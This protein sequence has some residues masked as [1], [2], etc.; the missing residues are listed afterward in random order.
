MTIT[1]IVVS[2]SLL[3]R[4]LVVLGVLSAGT[5]EVFTT[6]SYHY[7]KVAENIATIGSFTREDAAPYLWEPYRLPLLP[8][9]MAL[10]I[11][12]TDDVWPVIFL[13]PVLAAIATYSVIKLGDIIHPGTGIVS[14]VLLA[15]YPVALYWDR[16][17]LTDSIGAYG[18]VIAVYVTLL[19]LRESHYVSWMAIAIG[20]WWALQL[21]RPPLAL[22]GLLVGLLAVTY[23]QTR[24]QW[25]HALVIILL[26]LPI[27][28]TLS[29][30]NY[31]AHGVFNPSLNATTTMR[32]YLVVRVEAGSD[33]NAFLE[34]RTTVARENSQMARLGTGRSFYGRKNAIEVDQIT[35]AMQTYG[36]RRFAEEIVTEMGEQLLAVPQ[37]RHFSD[38][39]LAVFWY[40]FLILSVIGLI[41]GVLA[42]RY[43]VVAL[44]M[45]F[46]YFLVSGSI[47]G[48]VGT[49]L[50]LPGDLLLIP[51]VAMLVG[52][53]RDRW[54]IRHTDSSR[55]SQV[56]VP[57]GYSHQD[58]KHP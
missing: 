30:M 22:A 33:P 20:A 47:S 12:L 9:L 34:H 55:S 5:E 29:L 32:E 26:T 42:R 4:L 21:L 50:R 40:S 57:H 27:P 48:W 49:R 11:R 24:L 41:V 19:A 13:T 17:L 35:A 6:D 1:F 37:S 3:V 18:I 38:I 54:R 58:D 45:M 51:V 16:Y 8:M 2:L 28:L 31:Q 52:Y 53:T 44:W 14:G 7:L 25:K 39:I 10:S 43:L 15:C 46:L 23:C 36:L 56:V